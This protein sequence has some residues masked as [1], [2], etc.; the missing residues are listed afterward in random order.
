MKASAS[1][2]GKGLWVRTSLTMLLLVAGPFA[3]AAQ[4]SPRPILKGRVRIGEGPAEGG[5]VVLHRIAREGS[6]EVDS[7]SL[8]RGGQF[9]IPLPHLPDHAGSSEI[10]LASYKHAGLVYFGLP[11]TD[12]AQLD[13]LY[14]IQAYDTASVPPGGVDLPLSGRSLFLEKSGEG[15]SVA[16]VFQIRHEGSRTWYS[17]EEGVVWSY[18]LPAGVANFRASDSEFP[19]DAVRF[20]EGS[21]ELLAPLQPGERFLMVRYDLPDGELVIPLK[22]HHERLEVLVREPAP[23]VE[24]MPLVPHPG[25]EMAPEVSFR[26]FVGQDLDGGTLRILPRREPW[27]PQA[28]WLGL[29]LAGL[30]G[31]AGV[32]AF[33]RSGA[34][35]PSAAPAEGSGSLT[36]QDVLW[37]VAVLDEEFARKKNP[38]PQARAEY[39]QERAR[40]LEQLRRL[41]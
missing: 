36:R 34:R 5:T 11:I 3:G 41:R 23:V 17:P 29:F 32:W 7:V 21:L 35:V 39:R 18:P 2:R 4:E 15:W 28:S 31:A 38:S 24:V 10:F 27:R 8:A 1:V 20:R 25:L 12:V 30:L 22:G 40:L 33:R 19:S 6:G 37:Q 26:R 16:D 14:L 13:S 9:E